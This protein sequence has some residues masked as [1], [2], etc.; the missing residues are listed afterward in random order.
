[1]SSNQNLIK[2]STLIIFIGE[3]SLII[4]GLPQNRYIKTIELEPICT[5]NETGRK[6][7]VGESLNRHDKCTRIQCIGDENLWQY[8]CNVPSLNGDCEPIDGPKPNGVY[9]DCCPKYLCIKKLSGDNYVEK[10]IYDHYGNLLKKTT[11]Q[12]ISVIN[13]ISRTNT[14]KLTNDAVR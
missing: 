9:P 5:D 6:L 7:L 3:Y 14:T 2:F 1:M 12:I 13:V 11:T 4:N 8:E 10:T